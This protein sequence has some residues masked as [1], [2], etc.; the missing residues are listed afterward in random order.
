MANIQKVTPDQVG[1]EIRLILEEYTY[2][3]MEQIE[4]ELPK[5]GR[6]VNQ[7]IK[8]HITFNASAQSNYLRSLGIQ[9]IKG[10]RLYKSVVWRAKSPQSSL[11]HLLENGHQ[12]PQGGRSKAYPHIIYGEKLVEQELPNLVEKAV[13]DNA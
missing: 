1:G 3:V 8:K 9:V 11:T 10:S 4:A 5:L 2:D 6:K 12:L 7:E 13:K